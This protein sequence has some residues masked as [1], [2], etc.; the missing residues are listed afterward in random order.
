[1]KKIEFTGFAVYGKNRD[2][3][4]TLLSL[5][6]ENGFSDYRMAMEFCYGKWENRLNDIV[7]IILCTYPVMQNGFDL[8][9]P[10]FHT[11]DIDTEHEFDRDKFQY[12]YYGI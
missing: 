1:M 10:I 2:G 3:N 6:R 4:Y 9:N 12:E 5:I 7:D 8:G 11:K